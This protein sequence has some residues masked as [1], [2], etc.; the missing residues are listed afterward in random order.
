MSDDIDRQIKNLEINTLDDLKQLTVDIMQEGADG[1]GYMFEHAGKFY[2]MMQ[3]W[4]KCHEMSKEEESLVQRVAALEQRERE[5]MEMM[6]G[7]EAV[8]T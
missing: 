7:M 3:I 5:R 2:S 8:K 6:G 1:G 4:T